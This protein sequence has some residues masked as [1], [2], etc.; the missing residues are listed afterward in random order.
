M[1]DATKVLTDDSAGSIGDRKMPHDAR[2]IANF[3][4]DHAAERGVPVS[5]LKL[6]KLIYFA[7]GWHLAKHAAPLVKNRF[8]AWR[9]GPVVRALYENL[10]HSGD[11]PIQ[12]R[13]TKFDPRTGECYV[14]SYSLHEE[15]KEFIRQIFEAYGYLHALR[16]SDITHESGSPWDKLWNDARG[17][18]HP[19]MTITDASIR[20]HFLRRHR[21]QAEH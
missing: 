4:L 21:K 13:A 1:G 5:I 15:E 9:D 19:G 11:K 7:H 12:D 10:P 17:V 2:E 14:A 20:E 8:E 6:L 3:I 16:L 18:S